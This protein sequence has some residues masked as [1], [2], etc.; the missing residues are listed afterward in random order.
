MEIPDIIFD[1]ANN[2]KLVEGIAY[3]RPHASKSRG[4][5][6]LSDPLFGKSKHFKDALSLERRV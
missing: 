1:P 5:K 3:V 6:L 2:G 4:S